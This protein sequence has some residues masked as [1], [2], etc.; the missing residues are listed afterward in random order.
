MPATFG[1][2]FSF[3]KEHVLFGVDFETTQWDDYRFFGQKDLVK[4]NWTAKAGVQYYPA[5]LGTTGYFNFV[6]YRAGVSFGNDYVNVDNKLPVYNISVGGAFPLKLKHS[7][8]DLQYSVMNV[9]FEYGNRGNKD[10]NIT[11][12][13][14]K[15]SVGFSLSDVWFRRQKYQ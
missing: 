2:G 6:R 11:E 4:N 8:Y 10:N 3:E 5:T 15:I 7:F 1:A 13:I 9:A 12:N 14:Y